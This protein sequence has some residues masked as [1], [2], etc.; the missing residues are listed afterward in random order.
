MTDSEVGGP[1]SVG[2]SAPVDHPSS[3]D[4]APPVGRGRNRTARFAWGAVAVILVAVIALVTY[5]L[6]DPTPR[7]QAVQRAA[8]APAVVAQLANVPMSVFDAVGTTELRLHVEP[9]SLYYHVAD[10]DEILDG[11][12]DLVFGEVGLPLAD[13]EWK[14]AMRDRAASARDALRRRGFS[15]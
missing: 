1:G 14:T 10:K 15:A 7:Q 9:M 11:M 12:V 2:L 13:A 5:A 8:T 4:A 6:T 3:P